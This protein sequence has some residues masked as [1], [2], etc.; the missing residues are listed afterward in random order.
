[1]GGPGGG[2]RLREEARPNEEGLLMDEMVFIF[3]KDT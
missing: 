2:G 3:G 1:M